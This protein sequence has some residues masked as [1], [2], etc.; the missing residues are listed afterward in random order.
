MKIVGVTSHIGNNHD[1]SAALLVDG[2]IVQA[3]AV[4][5][6]TRKK[7]DS[8]F[9]LPVIK[10]ILKEKK[11]KHS[12][13]DYY[14]SGAPETNFSTAVK[15]Y[16]DGAKYLSFFNL[17][18]WILLNIVY[19][20]KTLP[21]ILFKRITSYRKSGFPVKKLLFVPHHLAHA[22]TAYSFSGMEKCL[23]VAW[24]GYGPD[25]SGY[26]WC[27][28]I[29]IGNKGSL[30]L[31]EQINIWNSIGLYYGAVTLALGFK[32]NDGEG[33]TMGY[34]SFGKSSKAV[35]KMREFFPSFKN[36][37]WQTKSNWMEICGVS[38][39][40]FFKMTGSYKRIMAMIKEYGSEQVAYAAQ[41]IFEEV[42]ESYIDYLVKKYGISDLAVAGGLFLNVKFNMKLLKNKTVSNLFIY[43]NPGDGGVAV[44]AAIAAY[45]ELGYKRNTEVMMTA[46]LGC[47]Y[48]SADI[49]KS[50]NG[51]KK[52]LTM[53]KLGKN[54][55][56][57]TAQKISEGKVIGWFEGKSEWG[58][59]ALGNRSVLADP[60][61]EET[62]ERINK[63]LKK[64]DWFMPFAPAIMD[65]YVN[66]YLQNGYGTPFMT[67][68]DDVK[69][70]KK[71]KIAAAIHVDGTARFQLV[72]KRVSSKYWSVIDEFRKITGV[73]VILNTSFNKHGLP[74][75][76]TPTDAL[77]HLVWGCLDE[78]IIGDYLFTRRN[79]K[80]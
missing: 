67:L 7:H 56:R 16:L 71:S 47:E 64:R 13:I 68:A 31:V 76:H 4:E 39:V 36:G 24:D 8:S 61:H 20:I 5:R 78:L 45:K 26:P 60:R 18:S 41:E 55:A 23:V 65:E 48:N 70:G 10:E 28:G 15:S 44:G 6:V 12:D 14:V 22:E 21:T 9:A 11:L 53:E 19:V 72:N 63:H 69:I 46:S 58:P 43:P 75:V 1:S 50:Y 35:K 66:E 57:V 38:R 80:S 54:T 42:C 52:I 3:E 79:D 51:F 74:I 37:K 62:K 73:P 77:E 59:R 27:A 29:Y 32:L 40:E 30:K 49:E 17:L 2:K 34:A 25:H 33:K